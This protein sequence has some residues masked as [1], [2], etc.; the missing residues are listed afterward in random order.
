MF[1]KITSKIN[2]LQ[3][4]ATIQLISWWSIS[5]VVQFLILH[6]LKFDLFYAF[7]DS[8]TT[9][10]LLLLG[11][12]I[13]NLI[14]KYY[15]SQKVITIAN[16][17]FIGSLSYIHLVISNTIISTFFNQ[18]IS[19][20]FGYNH[21]TI[22]RF[23]LVYFLFFLTFFQLWMDKFKKV[24]AQTIEKLVEIERQLNHAELANIQ[25]QLQPH[26]LFNSLNSISALTIVKPDEARRMVQLLSDFL[27]GTLSREKE[28]MMPL[29]EEINYLNLYLEIEKVRFGHRLNVDFNID[30]HCEK[31]LLP[32]LILQPIVEN[33]IKYG[34]YGSTDDVTISVKSICKTNTLEISISN[35]YTKENEK[36][37]KGLGFGLSSIQRK[38]YL[39]YGQN[40]LLIINKQESQFTT[41]LII[42][43]A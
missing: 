19:F 18:D 28:K 4:N 17:A 8:F 12:I 20:Q 38:L 30:G 32:S 31:A 2:E 13:L 21:D 29:S 39:L 42:P 27:R 10:I 36:T 16:I 23:L 37:S 6:H 33:A 7:V 14:L 25:Q 40:D 26:F 43:Q 9:N 35:P 3:K 41:T 11:S 5:F 24:Q 15:Q 1:K 22:Y 34:L